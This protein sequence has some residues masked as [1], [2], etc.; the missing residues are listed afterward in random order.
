MQENNKSNWFLPIS[1]AI[2]MIVG[3]ALGVFVKGNLSASSFG[4]KPQNPM[5]EIMEIVR[6]K[7]VDTVASDSLEIKLANFYLGGLDPHSVYIPPA[8]LTEVN[9]Q[10]TSNYKGIGIEFQQFR[11]SV[12]VAYVIKDGP[13]A[14]AGLKTGDILLK[15]DDSI[16]L[17]GKH[18]EPDAIR[19]KIKGPTGTSVKLTLLRGQ[20]II[21]TKVDRDNVPVSSV[22][23]S[24]MI[25]DSLGYIRINKF[26]D[27]TYEAFMQA[28]DPL[29][30]KGM[31]SLVIDLRGNGGG[32]LSEAVAIADELIG[33]NKLIVYT[34][35]LHSPKME[36][37]T[38][39]EGLFEQGELTIL[40]DESSASA[41]EVL[42]GALQ[43]WD[44]ATIVGR[45][46]FGKGLVQQQFR[47]SNGG[48][49]RLTTAKYY[50][51]LGRNIQRSYANGKSAYEH[52][53]FNRVTSDAKGIPD[54]VAKGKS[55]KTAKGHIV[56]GGGGIFPD[57]W[58][59]GHDQFLD[60]NFQIIWEQNLINDFAFQWYLKH[61]SEFNNYKTNKDFLLAYDKIDIWSP[62]LSF[63]TPAQKNILNKL[64]ANKG[65]I[66][67]QVLAMLSRIKWYK[68][69]Y[70]E[71]MNALDTNFNAMLPESK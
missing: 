6:S 37:N 40:M 61:Q 51:P 46:S 55:Y 60:S 42:A 11:D 52:A 32:I 67:N 1:Y 20:Q 23:A 29:V 14:K 9:E 8:E 18:W 21:N 47:L 2:V 7:Y 70:F 30:Q 5:E 4:L 27:R 36:Y 13:A 54:S 44:R 31:K 50:T 41:S 57:K 39:R 69:G 68:E 59:N 62:M 53:F 33:G 66:R 26:A 24:Y 15:A 63:A 16:Q 38:R 49:L 12:F 28:L 22:D 10:L 45:T 19:Q 43:D 48:A 35:G 65:Y 56:Y 34:Q 64:T 25:R 58:V 3:V 71:T 17:S